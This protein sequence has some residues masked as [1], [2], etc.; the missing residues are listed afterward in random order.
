MEPLLPAP[1]NIVF[2][3]YRPPGLAEEELDELNLRLGEQILEDGRVYAGTT[4]WAGRIG[5]RPAFVN[6]RT[7]AA[8][9]ELLLDV[10][11]DLGARQIAQVAG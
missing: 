4:R 6:W 11:R 9:A 5:F 10:V 1:L 7:T 8:D 3:R 2:F